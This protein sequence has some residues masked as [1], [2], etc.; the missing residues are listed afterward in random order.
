MDECVI[1]DELVARD[2]KKL[3][4][5]MF[6]VR[7]AMLTISDTTERTR[8]DL[9]AIRAILTVIGQRAAI[10]HVTSFE[11][12]GQFKENSG[13]KPRPILLEMDDIVYKNAILASARNLVGTSYSDVIICR[14]E[15][16][17]QRGRRNKLRAECDDLNSR[18]TDEEIQGNWFWRVVNRGG[19]SVRVKVQRRNQ[20]PRGSQG[21][22]RPPGGDR[23]APLQQK[24]M[25][26]TDGSNVNEGPGP[27]KRATGRVDAVNGDQVGHVHEVS[28]LYQQT[29]G[30]SRFF[31]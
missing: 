27:S 31:L 2:S 23:A 17:I 29:R 14:D 30:R 15:T 7:E 24:R 11:R 21:A 13:D 6:R 20:P 26:E 16:D 25:L 9:Q 5:V 8:H 3:N 12:L 1:A 18:L 19:R 28:P 10:D 22:S 4:L